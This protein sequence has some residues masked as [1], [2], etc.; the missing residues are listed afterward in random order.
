MNVEIHIKSKWINPLEFVVHCQ[1]I[2]TNVCW[3][4]EHYSKCCQILPGKQVREREEREERE[5]ERCGCPTAWETVGECVCACVRAWLC[6]CGGVWM[7]TAWETQV[8]VYVFDLNCMC[9]LSTTVIL[10]MYMYVSMQVNDCGIKRSHVLMC[11]SLIL[12]RCYNI[13]LMW[14]SFNYYYF[15]FLC[16]YTKLWPYCIIYSHANTAILNFF[17]ERRGERE[18]R[19][20]ERGR[21]EI[22]E[23]DEK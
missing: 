22:G 18:R 1:F 2:L 10:S 8:N 12:I 19:E 4:M 13:L 6:V 9:V 14:C 15:I 20:R 17:W 7:V 16:M 5:R 11:Y 3:Q 21:R 23:R